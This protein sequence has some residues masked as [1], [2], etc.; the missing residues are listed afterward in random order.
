MSIVKLNLSGHENQAL[1]RLGFMK[2]PTVQVDLNDP[3]LPQ[4]LVA[5]LEQYLT[6]GDVAHVVFPGLAPLS[7]LMLVAI[8]GLT[9]TF[10]LEIRLVNG[11]TG[12]VPNLGTDLQQ[13]RN[14][15]CRVARDD[16]NVVQL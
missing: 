16:G 5:F 11:P 1:L 12:F 8:H 6:S 4:K 13:F 3:D 2:P 9:G 15:T 7:R 14:W 10:P